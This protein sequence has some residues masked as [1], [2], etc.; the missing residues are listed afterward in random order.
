[1]SEIDPNNLL[2]MTSMKRVEEGEHLI[3]VDK[4]TIFKNGISLDLT[5]DECDAIYEEAHCKNS[6]LLRAG[7]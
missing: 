3:R 2:I 5:V 1:M 7:Y 6:G 4:V